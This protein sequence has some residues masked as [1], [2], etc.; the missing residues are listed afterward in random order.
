MEV[1]PAV[2]GNAV[3]PCPG[4]WA[5]KQHTSWMHAFAMPLT[6]QEERSDVMPR[7]Q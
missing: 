4:E 2:S 6:A 3:Q 1:I 7:S 5:L